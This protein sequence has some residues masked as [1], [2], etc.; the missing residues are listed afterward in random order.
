[1]RIQQLARAFVLE[2]RQGVTLVEVTVALAVVFILAALFL[3]AIQSSR[4]A[5]RAA[6][7]RARM[8]QLG[9]AVQNFESR[10]RHYPD[11]RGVFT[12]HFDLLPDLQHAE[13]YRALIPFAED[14]LSA[15]PIVRNSSLPVLQCPSDSSSTRWPWSINFF[16]NAGSTFA[17]LED[18]ESHA[19]DYYIFPLSSANVTDGLSNTAYVS[20]RLNADLASTHDRRAFWKTPIGYYLPN[21]LD[22]FANLCE[23]MPIGAIGPPQNFHQLSLISGFSRYDHIVNPNRSSC[24]NF[25]AS[26]SFGAFPANSEHHGGVNV[27]MADGAVRFISNAISRQTWRALGTR[28][29]HEVVSIP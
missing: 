11:G 14:S 7:C 1:M 28:N 4:S 19:F 26:F 16:R 23:S 29:G 13:L 15:Q 27:L 12:W 10:H 5:A 22:D 2:K 8:Q 3:P 25:E 21:Q 20:E 6:T 9:V 17:A 24:R 18:E